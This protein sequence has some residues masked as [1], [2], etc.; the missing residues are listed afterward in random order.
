MVKI[1]R[2]VLDLGQ[3]KDLELDNKQRHFIIGKSFR[4]SFPQLGKRCKIPWLK[5]SNSLNTRP[6][7]HYLVWFISNVG[8]VSRFTCRY[9][10]VSFKLEDKWDWPEFSLVSV[11]GV[12]RPICPGWAGGTVTLPT[13]FT[14]Q[15]RDSEECDTCNIITPSWW[16]M[17][18]TPDT[19]IIVSRGLHLTSE[20]LLTHVTQVTS[21]SGV[22]GW[23]AGPG[24]RPGP[25]CPHY[26]PRESG[27]ERKERGE[28]LCSG[29]GE[30]RVSAGSRD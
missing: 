15:R 30:R 1:L 9:T 22:C 20:S 6:L 7:F 8:W 13:N 26:P 21:L 19:F 16:F 29:M 10:P 17:L 11:S 28:T 5:N 4:Y 2:F 3:D 24:S 18:A 12:M 25:W 23:C 27:S 14:R